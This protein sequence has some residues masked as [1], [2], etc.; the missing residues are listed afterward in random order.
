MR[1][2]LLCI[3]IAG[4]SRA[5][6]PVSVPLASPSGEFSVTTEISGEEAG[7]TRRFCVR[8]K[9]KDAQTSR[10]TSF[11]TGAS[12]AQKWA[13]AWS[14]SGA[15]VLYSSDIGTRAYDIKD[16]QIIERSPDKAE[17][18]VARRAYKE[19]YSRQPP[20]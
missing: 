15:I 8:L 4:C 7:P 12:D 1:M 10:E 19:K 16:G 13:L 5:S 2:F 17:K 18:D 11:Q 20:A 3:V 6:R 14:P 9:L